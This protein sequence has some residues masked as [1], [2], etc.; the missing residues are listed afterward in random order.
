MQRAFSSGRLNPAAAD[1][2][3]AALGQDQRSVQKTPWR[4]TPAEVGPGVADQSGDCEVG[5]RADQERQSRAFF[6]GQV[7]PAMQRKPALCNAIPVV[8]TP[9]MRAPKRRDQIARVGSGRVG[10]GPRRFKTAATSSVQ[11]SAPSPGSK[12]SQPASTAECSQ[13]AVTAREKCWRSF[14]NTAGGMEVWNGTG[15]R[16]SKVFFRLCPTGRWR[17]GLRSDGNDD[18][19]S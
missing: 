5:R 13:R 9:F 2:L 10:S 3:V 15:T 18:C 6:E 8:Q 7:E 4:K 16:W 17:K 11:M 1:G 14:V 12:R 19:G